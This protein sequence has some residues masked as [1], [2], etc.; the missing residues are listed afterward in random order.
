MEFVLF[1]VKA[2]YPKR[3]DDLLMLLAPINVRPW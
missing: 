1:L 2:E 3:M